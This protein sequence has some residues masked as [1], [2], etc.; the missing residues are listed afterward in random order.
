M[1]STQP[2]AALLNHWPRGTTAKQA[3]TPVALAV[4]AA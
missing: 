4:P 2:P 3:S 1:S